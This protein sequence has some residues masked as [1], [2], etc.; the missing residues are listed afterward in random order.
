MYTYL[1]SDENYELVLHYQTKDEQE[2]CLY[3]VKE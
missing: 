1:P 3:H 2:F